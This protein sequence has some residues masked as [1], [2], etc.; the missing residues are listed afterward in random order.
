MHIYE[1][2]CPSILFPHARRRNPGSS[3]VAHGGLAAAD[4]LG[5]VLCLRCG[6]RLP[7]HVGRSICTPTGERLDVIHDIAWPPIGEAGAFHELP[8]RFL[9]A[10]NLP[11]RG[12]SNGD[13]L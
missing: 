8:L 11:V 1:S 10:S 9:A 6:H 12:P 4:S 13:G 2:S 3:V 5:L 7:L